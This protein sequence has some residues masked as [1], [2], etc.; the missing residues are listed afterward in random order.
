MD[1]LGNAFSMQMCKHDGEVIIHRKPLTQPEFALAIPKCESVI[2]HQDMCNVLK[3]MFGEEVACNRV[4]SE[5]KPGDVLYLAQYTGPRLPEGATS[6]PEGAVIKFYA[7][8]V[9]F[10]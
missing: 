2:G 10:V 1:Y 8:T 6:L 3:E 7:V 5:L 9:E 4:S